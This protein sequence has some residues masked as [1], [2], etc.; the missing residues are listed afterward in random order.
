MNHHCKSRTLLACTLFLGSGLAGFSQEKMKEKNVTIHLQM[1]ASERKIAAEDSLQIKIIE[2][3][4]VSFRSQVPVKDHGFQVQ[5]PE[6]HIGKSAS[7]SFIFGDLDMDQD[8]RKDVFGRQIIIEDSLV[9]ALNT[10][11]RTTKIIHGQQT[12]AQEIYFSSINPLNNEIKQLRNKLDN[13][14]IDTPAY[15]KEVAVIK[16]QIVETKKKFIS[17]HSYAWKSI[18]ILEE[19]I[20]S[21][22]STQWERDPEMLG[23]KNYKAMYLSLDK[24][25]RDDNQALFALLQNA[26]EKKVPRLT[27]QMPNGQSF[28][29]TSLRGKVV[30]IDFWG[31]WCVPC[32]KG[33]PHLKS[34]YEK[35]NGKGFE[36][37][38]VCY[39]RSGNKDAQWAKLNKAVADDG[40]P[41]IQILH[42]KEKHNLVSEF[43]VNSFPTK[44]LIDRDGKLLLRIGSDPRHLLD[45]KLTE[46]FGY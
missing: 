9:L 42:E 41:W 46:I 12:Q 25:L 26:E 14:Y 43:A 20:R 17:E 10:Q 4:A 15:T 3:M 13:K 5:V 11:S 19:L 36:I 23:L 7:V 39:E 21:Y 18:D 44:F 30:L 28:D 37:V 33:H 16:A 29:L 8:G 6:K 32:R 34:L 2:N 40:L 22:L 27:G 31:S 35:Y 38:G 1:E 24:K 45:T